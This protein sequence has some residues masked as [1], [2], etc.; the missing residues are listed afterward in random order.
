MEIRR[1]FFFFF[2]RVVRPW[3]ELTRMVSL[4]LELFKS[5]DLALGDRIWGA[6]GAG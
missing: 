3:D 2:E 6:G 4:S 5:L 1:V